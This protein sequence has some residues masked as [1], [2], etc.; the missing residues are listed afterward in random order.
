MSMQGAILGLERRES[1]RRANRQPLEEVA[2]LSERAFFT[3]SVRKARDGYVVFVLDRKTEAGPGEYDRASFRDLYNGYADSLRSEAFLNRAD[4]EFTKLSEANASTNEIG[5]KVGITRKSSSA[6]RADYDKQ[7]SQLSRELTE[8]QNERTEIGDAE[9]DE[10]ATV[11][12]LARKEILDSE[13]EGLR[14]QQ[15]DLNRERSLATRLVDAS[16]TLKYQGPWEELERSDSEVVFVRL[17]GVYT[18]RAKE[19][20]EE[21]I[22]DRVLDLEFARAE[23][24]RGDLVQDL[25]TKGFNQ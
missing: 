21:Q 17:L 15:A 10:N 3:R 1:E 7:S 6:V 12:Q 14:E 18:L 24:T 5:L 2:G 20:S 11:E 19:Q 16:P 9:R 23:G 22:A 25:I 4:E 13:I 8:L